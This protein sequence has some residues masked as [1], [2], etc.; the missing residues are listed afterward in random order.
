ML[1][2]DPSLMLAPSAASRPARGIDTFTIQ[3]LTP[4]CADAIIDHWLEDVS[5]LQGREQ[6]LPMLREVVEDPYEIWV[7]FARNELTGRIELRRR[8]V[9]AVDAGSGRVLGFIADAVAGQWVSFNLFSG[10]ATGA[11]RLRVG[12]LL[13]GRP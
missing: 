8:Y 6:Y 2:P 3:D 1:R 4:L 5:R 11:N 7:G 10:G 12:M 9:K 13:W